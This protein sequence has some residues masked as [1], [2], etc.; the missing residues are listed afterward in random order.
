MGAGRAILIAKGRIA[1]EDV[2]LSHAKEHLEDLL[3]RAARG[4]DVRISDPKLGTV[5]LQPVPADIARAEP[6]YPKRI[7][8]L[9]KGLVIISDETLFDPLTEAELDWLSGETSP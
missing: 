1:M 3:A 6:P 5:K 7:P 2:T 4:E 9:M 8:G